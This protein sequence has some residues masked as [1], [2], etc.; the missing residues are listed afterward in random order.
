MRGAEVA[1]HYDDKAMAT[2]MALLAA[3]SFWMTI[4]VLLKPPPGGYESA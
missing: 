1:Q 2:L 3:A 4:A